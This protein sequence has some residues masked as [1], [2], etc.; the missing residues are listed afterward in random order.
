MSY[1]KLFHRIIT[2]SIW[3]EPNSTRIVWITMLAMSN[4]DGY[5][6]STFKSLCLLSRTTEDECRAAINTFLSP[7]KDSRS[8][9]HDGR[10]IEQIDGGWRIL[11]Y[12][13]YRNAVSDDPNAIRTRERVKRFRD[14]HKDGDAAPL[15]NVTLRYPASASA[16]EL[17]SSKGGSGGDDYGPY[18]AAVND[19]IACR[20]E[21][22]RLRGSDLALILQGAKANPR[23]AENLQ[24]FLMDAANSRDPPR[25]PTGMLRA[26]MASEGPNTRGGAQK[27]RIVCT[28]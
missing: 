19:I 21:F 4:Q 14:K 16:S 18:T 3:D 12:E 26:F 10:R 15:R 7:D 24:E 9:E 13:K 5:V 17:A 8:P 2:S 23:Y 25:N 22:A 1:T 27:P 11:N 6:G 20:P 28:M